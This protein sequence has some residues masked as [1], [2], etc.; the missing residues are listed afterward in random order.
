M[1]KRKDKEGLILFKAT[2]LEVKVKM[3]TKQ[4]TSL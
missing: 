4:A 2:N 1:K 3:K